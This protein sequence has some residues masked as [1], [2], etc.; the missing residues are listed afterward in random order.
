MIAPRLVICSN[1]EALAQAAADFV[2]GCAR[3]AIHERGRFVLALAGGSTPERMY[4][5]LAWPDRAAGIDWP[6]TYVF[7]GDERM[8]PPDDPRSNYGMARRSL[9]AGVPL[10]PQNVFPIPT[11]GLTAA[12]AAAGYAVTL[13]RFFGADAGGPSPPR[14]DLILLGLGEDGHTAS[15]FPGAA[16]LGMEDA[17]VTWSPPGTLPPPVD[18]VTMTYPVFNTA[19]HVAF[20]AAGAKKAAVLRDLLEGHV[21]REKCPAAGIRPADGTV[22]WFVD[23]DA[24]SLLAGGVGRTS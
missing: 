15:L 2:V 4:D 16:A 8:V 7:M 11:Q 14:F 13:A 12:E 10:P 18:R 22:T 24:A 23:G 5:T 17:W 6:T 21:T 19:R 3:E 9:L 1:L 20:L